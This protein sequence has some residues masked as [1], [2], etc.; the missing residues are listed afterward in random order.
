MWKFLLVLNLALAGINA[1]AAFA[2][3]V[4]GNWWWVGIH[5][6]LWPFNLFAACFLWRVRPNQPAKE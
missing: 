5:A 3:V 4:M 2:N 1:G 6:T